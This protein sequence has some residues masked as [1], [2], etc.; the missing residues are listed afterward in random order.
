MTDSG[1][2]FLKIE[3]D[4]NKMGHVANAVKSKTKRIIE[5]FKHQEYFTSHFSSKTGNETIFCKMCN[6]HKFKNNC[7]GALSIPRKALLCLFI[8][9]LLEKQETQDLLCSVLNSA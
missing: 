4:D 8:I 5:D 6:A 3:A 7:F 9:T 2:H 1:Q